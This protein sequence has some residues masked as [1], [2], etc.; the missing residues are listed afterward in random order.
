V[1]TNLDVALRI[2]ADL[3]EAQG[4]VDGLGTSVETVGKQAEGTSRSVATASQ[5]IDAL[6]T[7]VQAAVQSLQSMD[8]RLAALGSAA[9]S[10]AEGNT[11]VAESAQQAS[12]ATTAQGEAEDAAAARIRAM[13]AASLDQ[14]RAID[15]AVASSL[16][17]VDA[18]RETAAVTGEQLAAQQA[19]AEQ[20]AK[21]RAAVEDFMTSAREVQ[22]SMQTQAATLTEITERQQ[23]YDEALSRGIITE[24]E[25]AK[26]TASLTQQQQ[27]LRA[28]VENLLNR[29]TPTDTAL[30]RLTDDQVKLEAALKSGAIT[31][32]QYTK[33]LEGIDAAR[34]KINGA[35]EATHNLSLNSA[36]ARREF[37]LLAKDIA[38]GQWGRL[39]QSTLTL[40]NATGVFS[41]ILTPVGLLLAGVTAGVALL[42]VQVVKGYL[43]QQ[44]FNEAL[45]AT[46]NYAGETAGQLSSISAQVGQTTRQYT[47]SRQAILALAASGQVSG[48]NLRNAAQGAVDFAQVTGQSIDQAVAAVVRLGKDPVQ[49]IEELDAQYHFLSTSSLQQIQSLEHEG[50]IADATAL[51]YQ[52]FAQVMRERAAEVEKNIGTVE[53]FWNVFK[54]SNGFTQIGRWAA[55]LGKPIDDIQRFQT[56]LAKYNDTY[57]AYQRSL[58]AG[59]SKDYQ[60]D[61]FAKSQSAYQELQAAQQAAQSQKSQAAADGVSKQVQADGNAA[62]KS[63][64]TLTS[65]IDKAKERTDA[66]AK[67]ADDLYKI[68]LAGGKLPE[69][70]NFDG[71]AADVPQGPGWDRLQAEINKRY[72]DPKG[73]KVKDTSNALATS[74]KQLQDQILSLGSTALG[75]VSGIWDKYTKAMLD[76]GAAG[77]KAIKAG[78]DVSQVQDQVAKVQELAAAARD[79]ALADQKRSLQ[80]SLDQATGQTADAAKLQVEA[81]FGDL[82]TDLQRRGDTA[83]VALVQKLINV[84]EASAQL[85]QL[86]Q[87]IDTVLQ[88]QSRQEQSIQAEQQS[89]LK[90]EYSARESILELHQKT[91]AQLEQLLPIYK[92]LAEATGNPQALEQYQ[93]LSAELDRLKLQTNDL[94]QAFDSGLTNG[95][96]QA[97]VGLATRTETVGQAFKQLGQSILQSLAQVA[98][99]KLASAA[100]DGLNSLA[101][102]GPQQQ[103]VGAGAAKLTIAGATVSASALLMGTNADKLQS[104]ATTLLIANSIGSVGGFAEGGFTGPG[105]KYDVAGVVHAGEYVQPATVVSQPGA[106]SFM[107]DFHRHGMAAIGAWSMAGYADGGYVNPLSG[108]SPIATAPATVR[109][110]GADSIAPPAGAQLAVRNVNI[111]DPSLVS[112]Y[113]QS[114]DGETLI[115]N[116]LSRNEAKVRQIA[117]SR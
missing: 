23:R 3:D 8:Q 50:N 107:R 24:E 43:E 66:L 78:A 37:G 89:G 41:A 58:T 10:A 70:I 90:T 20:Y 94:K 69:G 72:A 64:D 116:T 62:A 52:Q 18:S 59:S 33:A 57:A 80:I 12:A 77:G 44:H 104:A 97:L 34:D 31:T 42:A 74:Q 60:D 29:Y 111:V 91:A 53:R 71:A 117:G 81:Q 28:E 39:E 17:S 101:G 98:A 112:D 11:R 73:P 92:Q 83:G 108:T 95:L 40:A 79:K 1:T 109:A 27:R 4:K 105:A 88:A 21:Q 114:S 48:N 36:Q 56:A 68:H 19:S 14:K 9:V 63:I 115:M 25:H 38:T 76:A 102:G 106:L 45:I 51:S 54:E 103:D 2:K 16:R 86:Q 47:E 32:A 85:Q 15:D 82:L 26:A 96:D 84:N 6:V 22:A 65:S 46:G 5:K 61:L 113:L 30:K 7:G 110:P 55:D 99:Q 49:A 67:A 100:I 35:G 75:P 87:Q 13:V 93:N